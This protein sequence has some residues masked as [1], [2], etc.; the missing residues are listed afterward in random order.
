MRDRLNQKIAT[1]TNRVRQTF[2]S[3]SVASDADDH[4]TGSQG[5]SVPRGDGA[6]GVQHEQS[7]VGCLLHTNSFSDALG[8][9]GHL[10][11]AFD[12]FNRSLSVEQIGDIPFRRNLTRI[13][14]TLPLLEPELE[15]AMLRLTKQTDYIMSP[16]TVGTGFIAFQWA[17]LGPQFDDT[18]DVVVSG[19]KTKPETLQQK[20]QNTLLAGVGHGMIEPPVILC[21][22]RAGDI[23]F[24]D[25]APETA[26]GVVAN[27]HTD[28]INRSV[29]Y[30][31]MSYEHIPLG[32][33]SDMQVSE[34]IR[35]V[36]D[37]A[38]PWFSTRRWCPWADQSM[39]VPLA[40]EAD[41]YVILPNGVALG[42]NEDIRVIHRPDVSGAHVLN[43]WPLETAWVKE[44]VRRGGVEFV[45]QQIRDGDNRIATVWANQAS[46]R[47]PL[48]EWERLRAEYIDPRLPEA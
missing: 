12:T 6:G 30:W 39:S 27:A 17:D 2:E 19:D 14:R 3:D 31:T 4:S 16:S 37:E 28:L 5:D 40:A 45:D 44:H 1:F 21:D 23:R 41:S 29:G 8:S 47:D 15:E 13:E 48:D 46:P 7:N 22:H 11:A 10:R 43:F 26:H 18:I 20:A 9:E 32:G 34:T 24:Q 36:V 25:V 42:R 35:N 38:S 33:I